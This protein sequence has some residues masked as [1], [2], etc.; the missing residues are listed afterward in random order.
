M[1]F[2]LNPMWLLLQA[3]YGVG[4]SGVQCSVDNKSK[5]V[6]KQVQSSNELKTC[7]HFKYE[8]VIKISRWVCKTCSSPKTYQELD[9]KNRHRLHWAIALAPEKLSR[10]LLGCC[11]SFWW[12][13]SKPTPSSPTVTLGCVACQPSLHHCFGGHLLHNPDYIG[14][15]LNHFRLLVLL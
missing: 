10:T 7:M 1:H 6:I 8:Q 2:M 5:N 4:G 14:K 12:C 9:A 3:T 11:S 13:H 15:S